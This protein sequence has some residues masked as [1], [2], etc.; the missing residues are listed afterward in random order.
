MK[1]VQGF[2]AFPTNSYLELD[3]NGFIATNEEFVSG[4][5]IIKQKSIK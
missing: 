1:I 3:S 4:N 2:D 5:T